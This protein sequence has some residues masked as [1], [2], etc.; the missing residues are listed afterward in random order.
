MKVTD[1]I[2]KDVIQTLFEMNPNDSLRFSGELD[3]KKLREKWEHQVTAV[4]TKDGEIELL[5]P[6]YPTLEMDLDATEIDDKKL[7]EELRRSANYLQTLS[8][9]KLAL[10]DYLETRRLFVGD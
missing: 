7:I 3:D 2:W 9:G 6:M 1:P 10:A 5:H 8:R 4:I